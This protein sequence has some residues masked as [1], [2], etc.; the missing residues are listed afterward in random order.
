MENNHQ[1]FFALL[2]AAMTGEQ[3]E[4]AP[5][6]EAWADIFNI[7][8]QQSVVGVCYSA[9]SRLPKEQLPPMKQMVKWV[10][11][12]EVIRKMNELLNNEAARL[13]QL[14]AEQGRQTAILKGQANARL[15]PDT[16]SR[17]VGD[18][19]IWVDGGKESVI[20]LLKKMGLTD[21]EHLSAYDPEHA[22]ANYHHVHLPTT[23]DHITVEVHYRP[24]SGIYN[25]ITNRR[26][27]QWMELEIKNTTRVELGFN[28]PTIKFALIMQLAHIQHHFLVEGI[29]LRQICDYY[30]LLKNATEDD[31]RAVAE[32]IKPLGL[33]HSAEALMWV[34]GEMLH[35]E[36]EKMYC[37]K[38]S[39]RGEWML[40]EMMEGGNFGRSAKR[41][42]TNNDILYSL[43][44][45]KHIW[46]L[47]P[48]APAEV[49]FLELKCMKDI[50]IRIPERIK[51]RKLSLRQ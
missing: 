19:D 4:A 13:T 45:H 43:R 30:C 33:R 15:Y 21:D 5:T 22:T 32:V 28:V 47:V 44:K 16:M 10:N 34:L 51:Y 25:P 18:I 20:A 8:K 7:A 38:D 24:S 50:I 11:A 42:K 6:D 27:Q 23:K 3:F 31:R 49:L 12:A 9:M 48:F 36:K 1:L 37:K 39:Y 14:F 46:Q 2:R 26:L 41:K 35:L 40:R 17:Q 29:G